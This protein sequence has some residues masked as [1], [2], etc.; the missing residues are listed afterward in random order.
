V[1]RQF[2]NFTFTPPVGDPQSPWIPTQPNYQQFSNEAQSA[3]ASCPNGAMFTYTVKAGTIISQPVP[4]QLGPMMI[5]L[6]NA[7]A[8]AF[9]L[10]QV[11]ALR[12]C[13]D[14]PGMVQRQPPTVPYTPPPPPGPGN[15]GNG[16]TLASNPGWCCLGATLL[17]EL[18]TYTVGSGIAEFSFTLGGNVPPGTSLA[19]AGPHSA[20]L[21][22]TPLVPGVYIYTITATPTSGPGTSVSI[23]DTLKVFG[24]TSGGLPAG[25]VGTDYSAQLVTAGGTDPVTFTLV[26]SLPDGLSLSSTGAITGTPTADGDFSFS[27]KFTDAEGGTCQASLTMVVDPIPITGLDWSTLVWDQY[28]PFSTPPGTI[29]GSGIGDS[30][31]VDGVGPG[32]GMGSVGFNPVHASLTYTGPNVN[33][34]LTINETAHAPGT[35]IGINVV[36]DGIPVLQITAFAGGVELFPFSIAAGVNSVI[37][38]MDGIFPASLWA[39]IGNADSDTFTGT[40]TT[41]P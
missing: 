35:N 17:A 38:V 21:G 4:V 14:V 19:S 32:A 20:V 26:G 8:L 5:Q 41:L 16:P 24:L 7:Q 6:L 11:W 15:T 36:Q 22:G 2:P 3:T 10:Q 31:S 28:V 29:S 1:I 9:A 27:V 37:E 18:N 33:C 25:I 30:F 13:I 12:I 34:L 39:V 40:F 23:T